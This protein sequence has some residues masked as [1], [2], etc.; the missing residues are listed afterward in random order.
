MRAQ[1]AE[2]CADDGIIIL[3]RTHCFGQIKI[4]DRN[5]VIALCDSLTS[6]PFSHKP[7]KAIICPVLMKIKWEEKKNKRENTL[8]VGI[9]SIP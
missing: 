2:Y 6:V 5:A 3:A 1:H 9:P 8:P 7:K 4:T